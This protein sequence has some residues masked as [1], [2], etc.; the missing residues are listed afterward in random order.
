MIALTNFDN[1]KKILINKTEITFIED[2][3]SYRVVT[4]RVTRDSAKHIC[5]AESIEDIF[6]ML[7]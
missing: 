1:G 3:G 7:Q 5:V 6:I 4:F 2:V